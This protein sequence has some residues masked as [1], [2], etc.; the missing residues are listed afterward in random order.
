MHY[1]AGLPNNKV[2]C[3]CRPRSYSYIGC[4]YFFLAI[5]GSN[6]Y[7]KKKGI[8]YFVLAVTFFRLGKQSLFVV[9]MDLFI[10]DLVIACYKQQVGIKT[11]K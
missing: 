5:M 6:L 3:S 10:S 11:E 8:M 4:I 2:E 9:C 7:L 1:M